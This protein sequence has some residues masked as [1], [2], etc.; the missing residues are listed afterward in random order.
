MDL[1]ILVELAKLGND[2]VEM[3]YKLMMIQQGVLKL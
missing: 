3:P 2:C 1:F